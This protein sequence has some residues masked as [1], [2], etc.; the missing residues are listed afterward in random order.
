MPKSQLGV[1]PILLKKTKSLALVVALVVV[2]PVNQPACL[3]PESHRQTHKLIGIPIPAY[4]HDLSAALGY[5]TH[6]P[7]Q[8]G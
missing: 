3:W 5:H 8:R 7:S 4:R 6:T 1:K 2:R